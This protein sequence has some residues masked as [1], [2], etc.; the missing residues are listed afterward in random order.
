RTSTR[1]ESSL[2]SNP[3]SNQLILNLSQVFDEQVDIAIFSSSGQILLQDKYWAT[4]EPIN[5]TVKHL[6]EGVYYLQIIRKEM[7][8]TIPFSKI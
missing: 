1:Q 8:E 4:G 2:V 6:P 7:V 5:V 3:I